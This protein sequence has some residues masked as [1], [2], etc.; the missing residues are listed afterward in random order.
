MSQYEV[1][2]RLEIVAPDRV[3]E[4]A[5]KHQ[6]RPARRLVAAREQEPRVGELGFRGIDFL[7]LTLREVSYRGRIAA[8]NRAKEVLCLVLQLF[9]VGANGKMTSGHD[10][11]P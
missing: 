9:Q 8:A 1:A 5:S 3:D 6:T 7:R 2:H 10:E 4:L 11:P